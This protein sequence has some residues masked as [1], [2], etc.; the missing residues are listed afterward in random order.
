MEPLRYRQPDPAYTLH[1]LSLDE[2]LVE[3]Y[4]RG[5]ANQSLW[6]LCH[7]ELGELRYVDSE[8]TAYRKANEQFARTA[9]SYA[10]PESAVWLQDY[11]LALAP[12]RLRRETEAFIMQFWHIP[13]PSVHVF[14]TCPATDARSSRASLATD[15]LGFHLESY[16]SKFLRLC[17]RVSSGG[18]DRS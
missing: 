18:T 8:W 14:R 5:Y 6:P 3:G 17:G 13:W 11:H 2:S 16:G 9:A 4:Y 12:A 15:L 10:V 7:A 1:R